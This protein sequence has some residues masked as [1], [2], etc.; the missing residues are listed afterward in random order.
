MINHLKI[1]QNH[2]LKD[3][4]ESIKFD[5]TAALSNKATEET[6]FEYFKF[7]RSVSSVYSSKIEGENIEADSFIKHQFLNVQYEADYTKRADDLFEAYSFSEKKKLNKKNVLK[8]HTLLSQHLL[9]ENQRGKLRN[10]V[11]FVLNEDDRIEYV[12]CEPQQV[13]NEW[14]SLFS[15]IKKL[16]KAE[17]SI[18]ETFYYAAFIHLVFLKIHPLYDG[19]GR[20]ARLV[21]KWFL[22][23]KLGSEAI[24]IE[25]EKNYH[26]Q[27]QA[28]YNN[29][30]KIGLEYVEL[31][32]VELDYSKSLDFLLM[33]VFSL[34]KK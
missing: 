17:L 22:N 21:E 5:P 4:E 7:Y 33:T 16:L 9:A 11:M 23:A 6:G 26:T 27:K 32:Y 29:I 18:I 31:D 3:F 30:R 34:E 13:A 24:S 2:L 19:N 10:N 15:D 1:I 8:A 25:L 28:Y 12:A 14:K 20:T